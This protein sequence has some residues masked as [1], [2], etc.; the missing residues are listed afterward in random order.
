MVD[1]FE[2]CVLGFVRSAGLIGGGSKVLVAVS[3]GADSVALLRVMCQLRDEGALE[4]EI[5]V[6]HVN[7]GLR[8][9]ESDGDEGFVVDAAEELGVEV[10][11]RRVNVAGYGKEKG[12]SVETAGRVLRMQALLEI[13]EAEGFGCVAT[14]HH[15]DD[16]AETLVHRL[17]RGCGFRG[18]GGIWPERF[19]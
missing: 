17:V 4:C 12:L 3:G 13:A 18:L 15:M 10:F 5:A 9:A 16:N 2:Q 11:C 1:G 19:L 14:A 8:G 7:H 6:G